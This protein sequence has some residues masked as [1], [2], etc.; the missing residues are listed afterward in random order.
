MNWQVALK[1]YL[2]R[3]YGYEFSKRAMS[4]LEWVSV[5]PGTGSPGHMDYVLI[6]SLAELYKTAYSVLDDNSK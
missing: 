4:H 5:Y 2:E 3:R 1:L 6:N